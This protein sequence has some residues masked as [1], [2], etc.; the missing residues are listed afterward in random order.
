[1]RACGRVRGSQIGSPRSRPPAPVSLPVQSGL[2]RRA[3][4]RCLCGL[5]G[6]AANA[7]RRGLVAERRVCAFFFSFFFFLLVD[8]AGLGEPK[9]V[10]RVVG[11]SVMT[12][13]QGLAER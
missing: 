10:L 4:G 1:M 2:G 3:W 13:D 6:T 12:T 5:A 8:L 9:S 7:A 11:R